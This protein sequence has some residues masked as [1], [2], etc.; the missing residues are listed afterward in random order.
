MSREIKR[1]D[2]SVWSIWGLSNCEDHIS[3]SMID[4]CESFENAKCY[5]AFALVWLDDKGQA[6][7]EYDF[8]TAWDRDTFCDNGNIDYNDHSD[9][10]YDIPCYFVNDETGE[11]S[12]CLIDLHLVY[13]ITSEF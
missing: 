6:E 2:S 1:D 5:D 9:T 10:I 8:L 3:E 13:V 12:K 11:E 7:M 4:H